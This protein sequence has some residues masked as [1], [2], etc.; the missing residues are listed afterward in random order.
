MST[1]K[2]TPVGLPKSGVYIP[3]ALQSHQVEIGPQHSSGMTSYPIYLD[4]VRIAWVYSS[5]N[6]GG[7]PTS[8]G[9]R[10]VIRNTTSKVW[11]VRGERP[12]GFGASSYWETRKAAVWAAVVQYVV[13]WNE[14]AADALQ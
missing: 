4:G 12:L 7:R 3:V 6:S 13:K 9:S 1:E 11:Q 2:R 8:R 10:I 14:D 5:E